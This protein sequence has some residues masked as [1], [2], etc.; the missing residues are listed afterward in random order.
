MGAVEPQ[1]WAGVCQ[2]L[3]INENRQQIQPCRGYHQVGDVPK[4][5]PIA[6]D[7]E[8]EQPDTERGKPRSE[9]PDHQR[10][11]GPGPLR[12]DGGGRI[13]TR[14]PSGTRAAPTAMARPRVAGVTG[15]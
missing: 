7:P 11:D 4:A 5:V 14:T 3:A 12:D 8:P 2:V 13:R 9:D 10:G 6:L 1:A 15:R